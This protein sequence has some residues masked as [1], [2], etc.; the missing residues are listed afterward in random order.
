MKY[1]KKTILVSGASGIVGYG[2]LKSLQQIEGLKLI[3]TSI[4]ETSPA[5]YFSDIF[6]IAPNTNSN[7]YF[8]WLLNIIDKYQIDMI[9]PTIEIDMIAWNKNRDLLEKRTNVLLNNKTLIELCEDKWL[10]YKELEK[11]NSKYAIPTY[12][13]VPEN[14]K[15]PF[16]IKPKRG[17]ASQ[18]IIIIKDEQTLEQNLDKIGTTHMVQPIIGSIDE[19]YTVSAFF[20]KESKLLAFMSLKRKL[21]KEGYT[22]IAQTIEIDGI[23]TALIELAE[24]FKPVGPTN[25]Q[26]RKD[27]NYL[28]LLEINPRISSATSIRAAFNYNESKMSIDYFLNNIIPTQPIIKKGKSIRYTEDIIIYDSNN[29]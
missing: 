4:Y 27:N 11:N 20:D 6:E 12:L 25:F 2:V 14:I 10:F 16:L 24:I 13:S 1:N 26:F 8:D 3:G 5:N 29:I 9:I 17:F 7:D 21:S 18:G 19:E 22:E 28:K 23:K 15:F